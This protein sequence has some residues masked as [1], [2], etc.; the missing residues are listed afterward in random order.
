MKEFISGLKFSDIEPFIKAILILIIGHFAI[1]IIIKGIKKGFTKSK[2]DA[3]LGRF[4]AK[5]INIVLH[6]LIVLS[7]LNSVGVSTTGLIATF[8]AA[9]IAISLGLK[10]SLGNV[11]GGILLIIS[12][13]FA[14]GDYISANGEAGNVIGIDLLHT[15]IQT[16]D[17]KIVSIPNGVLINQSIVNFTGNGIRRVDLIFPIPYDI[18]VEVAKSA[19]LEVIKDN[20]MVLSEPETPFARVQSY[21]DSAVNLLVR[22]WCDTKNYW[23]VYFDLTEQIRRSLGENGIEIPFNQLDVHIKNE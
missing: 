16:V 10:D 19:A 3:S 8:S 20:K 1:S 15:R 6:I 7:A 22:A 14:T 2:I 9:A 5:F 13:C 12:P 23:S 18:D 4:I 11:A 17:G 21:G